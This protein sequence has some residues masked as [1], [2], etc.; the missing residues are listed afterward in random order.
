MS[1]VLDDVVVRPAKAEVKEPVPDVSVPGA[2]VAEGAGE[3]GW[4]PLGFDPTVVETLSTLY[5]KWTSGLREL[6]ANMVASCKRAAAEY[7]ASPRIVITVHGRTVRLEDMDSC[8]MSRKVFMEGIAVAG[9]TGNDDPR[10]PGQWGLGSLA[11]VMMS[12]EMLIESH[13]RHTGEKF[14]ALALRGGKF[15]TGGGLPEPDFEWFGTRMTLRLRDGLDPPKAVAAA[16]DFAEMSGVDTVLRSH[17]GGVPAGVPSDSITRT[18]GKKGVEVRL[19]GSGDLLKHLQDDIGR[20]G[21][22]VGGTVVARGG[23]S[24]CALAE[25]NGI[26]AVHAD[27]GDLEVAGY[28]ALQGEQASRRRYWGGNMY[29]SLRFHAWLAGMPV[30]SEYPPSLAALNGVSVHCKNERKY[31][32]TPD[33]ERLTNEAAERVDADAAALVWE[34]AAGV[35]CGSLGEYLSDYGNRLAEAALRLEE[36]ASQGTKMYAIVRARPLDMRM[37][38]I[39]R[40]ASAPVKVFGEANT[41]PGKTQTLWSAMQCAG[42][43]A[44]SPSG[45]DKDGGGGGG[46]KRSGACGCRMHGGSGLAPVLVV[47]PTLVARKAAAVLEWCAK[48]EPDRRAIVFRPDRSNRFDAADYAEIGAVP[49]DKFMAENGIR[50]ANVD[51]KAARRAAQNDP[52]VAYGGNDGSSWRPY[53]AINETKKIVPS[54][55]DDSVVWCDDGGDMEAMKSIVSVVRCGTRVVK[56]ARRPGKATPFADHARAGGEAAYHTSAGRLTGAEIAKTGRKAVLVE[57][58]G[59]AEDLARLVPMDAGGAEARARR[60]APC[61]YKGRWYDD[62]EGVEGL[63]AAIL[64]GPKPA[65]AVVG[66][67]EEIALCAAHL[68]SAGAQYGAWPNLCRY[69]APEYVRRMCA[70]GDEIFDKLPSWLEDMTVWDS[71]GR[72]EAKTLVASILHGYLAVRHGGV[73]APPAGRQDDK[74]GKE[75]REVVPNG[76]S[77]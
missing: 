69:D 49:I 5:G 51:L 76:A 54:D 17:V 35:R 32:P 38:L 53:R 19:G 57:Y 11:F 67:A 14:A 25:G 10:S 77:R 74:E 9:N 52:L 2:A 56:C 18:P 42:L 65:L 6:Y 46:R 12:D 64:G 68:H 44:A 1:V 20:Q 22:D 41:G 50:Q 55:A 71:S 27:D 26:V 45:K 21:H 39:A 63:A 31:S 28:M 23:G 24:Q 60:M 66:K 8:G 29:M 37:A 15:R 59:D 34:K 43:H 36:C 48:N 3:D 72:N 40:A 7:G 61:R 75:K 58:D 62:E 13:S 16:I 47:A 33:R 73:H 30:E 70:D 4:L